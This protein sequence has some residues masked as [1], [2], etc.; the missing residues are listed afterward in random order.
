MFSQVMSGLFSRSSVWTMAKLAMAAY[1]IRD[2]VRFGHEVKDGTPFQTGGGPPAERMAAATAS[3]NRAMPQGSQ[4][5]HTAAR[6]IRVDP[7]VRSNLET[8]AGRDAIKAS[9]SLDTAINGQTEASRLAYSDGHGP[10]PG[11]PR[12]AL[13]RNRNAL[14]GNANSDHVRLTLPGPQGRSIDF[15]ASGASNDRAALASFQSAYPELARRHGLPAEIP[16][17]ASVIVGSNADRSDLFVG[18]QP[19]EYRSVSGDQFQRN[20]AFSGSFDAPGPGSFADG[21]GYRDGSRRFDMAEIR[22]GDPNLLRAADLSTQAQESSLIVHREPYVGA[23]SKAVSTPVSL[24]DGFLGR[25][26]GSAFSD[27]AGSV[28]VQGK[29]ML[30]QSVDLMEGKRAVG[31]VSPVGS[32]MVGTGPQGDFVS[33]SRK[34]S[35]GL[36]M[37]VQGRFPTGHLGTF[38][39]DGRFTGTEA[40]ST[41]LSSVGGAFDHRY[42]SPVLQAAKGASVTGEKD[43]LTDLTPGQESVSTRLHFGSRIVDYTARE[44]QMTMLERDPVSGVV[45][46]AAMVRSRDIHVDAEGH[47]AMDPKSRALLDDHVRTFASGRS[48]ADFAQSHPVEASQ[49]A[50]L[51]DDAPAAGRRAVATSTPTP[52]VETTASARTIREASAERHSQVPVYDDTAPAHHAPSGRGLGD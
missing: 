21:V 43:V 35:D 42:D 44:G 27:L 45:Q 26:S 36:L 17:G 49:F 7:L 1:V 20:P 25:Q 9:Q 40:A 14:G 41:S 28:G 5:A 4:T 13:E 18:S 2:L 8:V 12:E 50:S 29:T 16:P 48:G 22:R 19:R 10:V 30:V 33:A 31:V 23:I 15:E 51:R 52:E 47:V 46:S 32:A 3:G 24:M 37:H 11:S 39:A 38:S 34:D 6:E